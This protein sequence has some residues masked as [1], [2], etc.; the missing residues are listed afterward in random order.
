MPP[1]VN[2]P[3]QV[4]RSKPLMP[5]SSTVGT[6][7]SSEERLAVVT[8]SAFTLPSLISGAEAARLSNMKS[9]WPDSSAS[10]A[11]AAPW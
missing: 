11:G 7:A 1:V 9:D 6:L 3:N 8:A 4:P 5:D 10:W 2:T